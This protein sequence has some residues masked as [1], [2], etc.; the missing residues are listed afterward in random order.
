[1]MSGHALCPGVGLAAWEWWA[2]SFS[3]REASLPTPKTLHSRAEKK[4]VGRP[5]STNSARKKMRGLCRLLWP[6]KSMTV[7]LSLEL[8][9][10]TLEQRFSGSLSLW[11]RSFEAST[12]EARRWLWSSTVD[13]T[14]SNLISS[15]LKEVLK[16]AASTSRCWSNSV[17]IAP[18][19]MLAVESSFQRDL[20]LLDAIL[21]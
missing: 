8:F 3:G 9:S 20:S 10:L 19:V 12:R 16:S 15:R 4:S 7:D 21:W 13:Q 6:A 17:G 5:P 2:R 14:W 1:M 18:I 11:P